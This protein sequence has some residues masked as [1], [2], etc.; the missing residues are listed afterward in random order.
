MGM[1]FPCPALTAW[2]LLSHTNIL[3][4]GDFIPKSL[5]LP[6]TLESRCS[7]C[8]PR[9]NYWDYQELFKFPGCP[10]GMKSRKGAGKWRICSQNHAGVKMRR[11]KTFGNQRF[12]NFSKLDV[13]IPSFG[14][15]W[16]HLGRFMTTSVKL[17]FLFFLL[18]GW[19]C[20][21]KPT[22]RAGP[23]PQIK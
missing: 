11:E 7:Q 16:V 9:W 18:V 15:I 20:C 5:F 3:I 1:A 10:A 21:A 17:L 6:Q 14:D 2:H 22:L 19:L 23:D 4:K 8:S 13:F 12:W